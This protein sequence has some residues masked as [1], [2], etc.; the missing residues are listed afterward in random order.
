MTVTA[1]EDEDRDIET[2]RISL[3]AS[4][5]VYDDVTGAVPVTVAD[6]D[7]GPVTGVAVAP[8][9]FPGNNPFFGDKWPYQLAVSWDV[10]ANAQGYTVQWIASDSSFDDADAN[11]RQ[12]RVSGGSTRRYT[13]KKLNATRSYK[14]RVIGT[15]ANAS[16]GAPS[17][18]VVGTP[19]RGLV[20]LERLAFDGAVLD[21]ATTDS[22]DSRKIF[23]PGYLRVYIGEAQDEYSHLTADDLEVTGAT[24]GRRTVDGTSVRFDM[25]PDGSGNDVVVTVPADVIPKGN[26]ART[27][28]WSVENLLTV[29]LHT[30]ATP[31]VTGPFTL[32]IDFSEAIVHTNSEVQRLVFEADDLVVTNGTVGAPYSS[33][34]QF[35]ATVTPR[36]DFEGTLRVRIGYSRVTARSNSKKTNL[37]KEFE[38]EV[39]TR[40]P[41][42][43]TAVVTDAALV[44]TYHEA[45]DEDSVPA[46]TAYTVRVNGGVAPL[47]ADDPVTV[48]G[49]TVTLALA[50]PVA[51]GDAVTVSYAVPSGDDAAPVRDGVGHLA[52]SLTDRS[53]TNGTPDTTAPTLERAVVN[54]ATLTLTWNEELD[55]GSVP[56]GSAFT[57]KVG[58]TAVTLAAVDPVAVAGQEVTLT[59]ASGVDSSDTVTVSYAAPQSNPLRDPAGNG[60]GDLNDR[61]VANRTGDTTAPIFDAAQVNGATLVLTWDNALDEYSVPAGSAFTVKV[62]GTAVPLAAVDPVA[63]AGRTVTLTLE[64]GVRHFDTVTVSYVAPSGNPVRDEAGNAVANLADESVVNQTPDDIAPAFVGA[65]VNGVTLTLTWN[66]SLDES[67]VPA[68]SAFTVEV[69]GVSASLASGNPVSLSGARVTLTLAVAA[70]A[71]DAVKVSYTAP[72]SGRVRD[73]VGN[74]AGNLSDAS[75]TDRTPAAADLLVGND[76]GSGGI[77]FGTSS[78]MAQSFVAAHAFTLSSI[79]IWFEGVSGSGAGI[80]VT[81]HSPS[82]TDAANPGTEVADLGTPSVT[83][84]PGVAIGFDAPANTRLEAGTYFVQ[85]RDPHG[86][87]SKLLNGRSR[88]TAGSVAGWSVANS[89]RYIPSGTDWSNWGDEFR[90]SVKGTLD[91]DIVAPEFLSAAVNG[92]TLV[93]TWDEALDENSVPAGPAF[94]VEVGGTEVDLAASNAVAV[95][96]RTVTLTLASPVL[97]TDRVTVSYTAPSSDSLRDA[98]GNVAADLAGEEVTNET[99]DTTA[100]ELVRATVEGAVLVLT[101]GEALN[102][103]SVPSGAAYTVKVDGVGVELAATSPVTVSGRMITLALDSPT[104]LGDTVT[105]SYAAP[106]TD[107]VKDLAGNAAADLVDREVRNTA[108]NPASGRPAVTGT[109]QVGA[110]LTAGLGQIVD[111]DGLPDT[112]FPDGYTLQ[113]VR[114]DGS[115]ETDIE[116]ATG[117]TYELV[118]DDEGKRVRVKVNFVDLGGRDEGPRYSVRYPVQGRVVAARGECPEGSDWCTAVTLERWTVSGT[119]YFRYSNRRGSIIDDTI[120]YKVKRYL[121]QEL[122][123]TIRRIGSTYVQFDFDAS[124]PEGTVLDL[125]GMEVHDGPGPRGPAHRIPLRTRDRPGQ[126]PCRLAR[127]S[128]NHTGRGAGEPRRHGRPDHCRQGRGGTDPDRGQGRHRR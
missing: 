39:D 40:R 26:L 94:S 79:E 91:V 9:P 81:L 12:A 78:R 6:N 44:L 108:N 1:P 112:A 92:A 105:V 87:S 23:S 107:P 48:S 22:D 77:S 50:S 121:L 19:V 15:R 67:S 110:T 83:V 118:G 30:S 123:Y 84:A 99:P 60:A 7:V 65:A 124:L 115:S 119:E 90:F 63:V 42:L 113:W 58:G 125:E 11:I 95:S 5:G 88:E 117:D 122:S 10:A 36:G 111:A 52:E 101:Y 35:D 74:H 53:V 102:E 97:D 49:S 73:I 21:S 25:V 66:E 109:A 100:P 56:A 59:L 17:P 57:V 80:E 85:V 33:R 32:K 31:P 2:V 54:G 34:S 70:V 82:S 45:L 75:V 14:I 16:D 68:G 61:S 127:R 69:N 64:S 86:G 71:G 28:T 98:T 62:G 43:E 106:D 24:V 103:G 72:S 55:T 3:V 29:N 114:V 20:R 38:I 120:E 116:G 46:K 51:H 96:G 18:V 37:P 13:I 27:R 126:R 89:R 4:G 8:P 47:A 93:L 41:R 128:G 76:A 104:E